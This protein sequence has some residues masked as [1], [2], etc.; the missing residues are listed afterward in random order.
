[1]KR[2]AGRIALA[3]IMALALLSTSIWTRELSAQ[4]LFAPP[5][6]YPVGANPQDVATGD[7]DS[8][9]W[10]DL[11]VVHQPGTVSV[12]LNRRD[13]TFDPATPSDVGASPLAVCICRHDDDE[14]PEIIT[15][16]SGS[17]SVSVLFNRGDG[18]FDAAIDYPV[19]DSPWGIAAEDLNGDLIAD[20][21]VVNR[22]SLSVSLL[23]NDGSGTLIPAGSF[24]VGGAYTKPSWIATADLDSDLDVD[25]VV[26][27][28]YFNLYFRE[29]YIEIFEND[30][31]GNFTSERTITL[32]LIA[33][34]PLAVG[35]D[36]YDGL[37]LAVSGTVDTSYKLSVLLNDGDGNFGDPVT[38]YAAADGR[39][40]TGDFDGDGDFDVAISKQGFGASSFSVLLNNG[41]ATFADAFTV[42]V[43]SD[44]MGMS[45]E[46]LDRDGDTDVAVAVS[47]ENT[48]AVA[49]STA[50]PATRVD[51]YDVPEQFCLLNQNYPNPFN[52]RTTIRYSLSRATSITLAIYDIRGRTVRILGSGINGPGSHDV[53][54]DGKDE[55]GHEAPNG[56]YAYRLDAGS[57][58]QQRKM[59]LLK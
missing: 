12:L 21:A 41:D 32:G 46:N 18:T 51:Q 37:D 15:S 3:F 17:N 8:D 7:L 13:G 14:F 38:Y 20:V 59:I 31:M 40:C 10:P 25:I 54:W 16:N 33:T 28:N 6:H 36:V 34:T 45:A 19:G 26:V 22:N 5:V 30:G 50:N 44:P 4:G 11:A 39:A 27:K 58:T 23:F 49:M 29:S 47:G 56:V 24:S 9:N 35:L 53:T 2:T 57:F 48:V 1:M 42:S 55:C 52:P 43:G